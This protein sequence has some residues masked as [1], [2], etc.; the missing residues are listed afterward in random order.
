MEHSLVSPIIY[1]SRL[2]TK[3]GETPIMIVIITACTDLV[4]NIGLES[5]LFLRFRFEDSG[6]IMLVTVVISVEVSSA[7]LLSRKNWSFPY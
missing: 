2:F 6:S 7:Y 5:C 4:Y 1:I 3:L